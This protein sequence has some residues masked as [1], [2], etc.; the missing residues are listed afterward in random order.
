MQG[1]WKNEI[2]D[3]KKD[4]KRK[5]QNRKHFIK[6][7]FNYLQK[8]IWKNNFKEI[9]T[10]VYEYIPEPKYWYLKKELFIY[11]SSKLIFS[12]YQLDRHLFCFNKYHY[13][14]GWIE[15]IILNRSFVK[16]KLKQGIYDFSFQK[17]NFFVYG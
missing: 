4:S 1:L 16:Q 13:Y 7:K 15:K 9:K 12:S 17:K 10:E 3:W 6:D 14:G 2:S 5:K 8:E 11:D